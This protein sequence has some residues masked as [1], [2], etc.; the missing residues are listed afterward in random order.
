M[1]GE[2]GMFSV[3]QIIEALTTSDYGATVLS[4]KFAFNK[5]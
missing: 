1:E 2:D 4:S 5:D 3:E